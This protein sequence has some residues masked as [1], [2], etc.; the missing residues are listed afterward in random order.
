MYANKFFI[1]KVFWVNKN[2]SKNIM[3]AISNMVKRFMLNMFCFYFVAM[4]KFVYEI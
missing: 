1:F 3:N 4:L 2:K